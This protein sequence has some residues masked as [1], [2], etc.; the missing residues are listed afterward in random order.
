MSKSGVFVFLAVVATLI[1]VSVC[2]C[3]TNEAFANAMHYCTHPVTHHTRG[4]HIHN[5]NREQRDVTLQEATH[6]CDTHRHCAYF[7]CKE[8]NATKCESAT[9]YRHR[10]NSPH[11]KQ[12]DSNT[13]RFQKSHEPCNKYCFEYVSPHTKGKGLST[14]Q[15]VTIDQAKTECSLQPHCKFFT[16][17]GTSD[18][19]LQCRNM[20]MYSKHGSKS[21]VGDTDA[22]G[23]VKEM[24]TKKN[25]QQACKA[26]VTALP[27]KQKASQQAYLLPYP[28]NVHGGMKK[29]S[30]SFG[31]M[32]AMPDKVDNRV[33]EA[34][35]NNRGNSGEANGDTNCF[36]DNSNTWHADAYDQLKLYNSHPWGQQR[37][38]FYKDDNHNVYHRKTDMC[39][40][41]DVE[42]AKRQAQRHPHE[43][44]Q[45]P[46]AHPCNNLPDSVF[47][48]DCNHVCKK[49]NMVY[50]GDLKM[51][52]PRRKK[53]HYKNKLVCD[54][55]SPYK[56]DFN[57]VCQPLHGTACG[58]QSCKQHRIHSRRKSCKDG[59]P[60]Y[61]YVGSYDDTVALFNKLT[62]MQQDIDKHRNDS[63]HSIVVTNTETDSVLG[64]VKRVLIHEWVHG[65]PYQ[66]EIKLSGS[67]DTNKYNVVSLSFDMQYIEMYAEDESP[68]QTTFYVLEKT[69]V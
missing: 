19:T 48:E 63:N 41:H 50:R 36:L 11:I 2:V 13:V 26:T 8:P 58:D 33:C 38:T 55:N 65:M 12:T 10:R 43:V 39:C 14:P 46:T 49:R 52:V 59:D 34:T 31:G 30:N 37:Y 60:Y 16:C 9:F 44:V 28:Y 53:C 17:D 57:H 54:R 69:H 20:K 62:A 61:T 47:S 15:T 66:I 29:H 21:N 35:H 7:T 1:V 42:H 4:T 18:D 6:A 67:A 56:T 25:F 64:T 68:Q 24:Y 40:A 51:C 22:S 5:I 32:V 45:L 23:K 27:P 3:Y